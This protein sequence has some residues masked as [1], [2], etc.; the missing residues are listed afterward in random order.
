MR[1]EVERKSSWLDVVNAAR[2]TQRLPPLDHEP[3]DKFKTQIIRAE[4]SPLRELRFEVRLFDIPYWVMGHLVRH[5]HAQPYVS[6]SRPDITKSGLDR[7]EMKQGEPVNLMLSLNAQEII[8]ISK[9]RLCSKASKETRKVWNGVISKL[10]DIEPMLAK[11]CVPS[12]CYRGFCPEINSCGLS[13]TDKFKI[14]RVYYTKSY[15]EEWRPIAGYKCIYEVSNYGRVRRIGGF[16]KNGVKKN[17]EITTKFC[18]THEVSLSVNHKRRDYIGVMLYTGNKGV[19][20]YIHRLVADAFIPNPMNLPQVNHKDGN[21]YNN[22]V[23]NLEWVTD[24]QNK[25]HAWENCLCKPNNTTPIKCNEN[26]I[27]YKSV[28]EASKDLHIERSGIFRNLRGKIPTIKGYTF[29]RI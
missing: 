4:H 22:A 12:C 27:I 2:F 23:D 3:S 25:R 11:Y 26:G 20:F 19:H 5:V 9:V 29:T 15:E 17:G 24:K 10:A 7:N 16:I 14:H 1:I 6:T 18:G 21:K 28:V 13:L 8:N